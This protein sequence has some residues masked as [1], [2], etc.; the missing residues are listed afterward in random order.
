[1]LEKMY[2]ISH[3]ESMANENKGFIGGR[4]VESPL[5][6]R[7]KYQAR[8]LAERLRD[9]GI[10]FDGWYSSTA[11]RTGQTVDTICTTTR[12]PLERI[13]R[14]PD[15]LE[16]DQGD[17]EGLRR[18]DVY[19]PEI[20]EKMG[21]DLLHF[22]HPNGESRVMAEERALRWLYQDMIPSHSGAIAG[23]VG[24]RLLF[25]GLIRNLL[26]W[27]PQEAYDLVLHNASVTILDYSKGRWELIALND[28]SHLPEGK[29]IENPV[30]LD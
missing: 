13:V 10:I 20:R 27:T 9:S 11:K 17:W 22:Q 1:M 30:L 15:L 6:P 26:D 2:L 21:R 5:S 14:T 24:H 8:L 4:S 12:Y 23:I 25:K 18:A 3:A 29:M 16:L 19:T 28:T 7:G